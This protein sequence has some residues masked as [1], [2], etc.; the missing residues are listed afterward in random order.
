MESAPWPS[1]ASSNGRLGIH[2]AAWKTARGVAIPKPGKSDYGLAK[3]YRV[4]S[5]LSCLG[6]M[7]EKVAA[8]LI[9]VHCEALDEFHPSQYGGS[10]Q[11]PAVDAVGVVIAQAQ[12]AWK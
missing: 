9:S 1:G 3:A 2:P 4:T 6:K 5:L 10:P 7:V 12:E 11:R 8:T